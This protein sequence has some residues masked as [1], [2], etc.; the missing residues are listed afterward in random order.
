MA[1]RRS[2]ET[3]RW[4]VVVLIE[5]VKAVCRL[6]L[7]RL[8]NSRPLLSPPL[9]EREIDPSKIEQSAQS[10]MAFGDDESSEKSS[11]S[12]SSDDAKWTMPRTGLS[13]PNLPQSSDIS[14]YLLSKVI[15]ADDIKPP[16]QL[17]HRVTGKAEIAEW[18]YILRPVV[19]AIAMAS[20]GKDKKSWRPW[21]IGLAL[22]YGA[23]QLAKKDFA[24]RFAG[25]LRGLT[26]LEKDELR[27]RGWA[28]A[29]WFMRGAFYENITK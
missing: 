6:L 9:P 12:V 28:M 15:T 20:W 23:R 3:T 4:R 26:G 5:V 14:S 29:W 2:S 10:D 8:T 21:L 18:L 25:G 24:E 19:Y 11:V 13:L 16:I 27:K 1:A 7:L 17:L 22:E